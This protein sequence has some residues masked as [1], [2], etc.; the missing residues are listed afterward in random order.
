MTEYGVQAAPGLWSYPLRKGDTL[1]T[2]DWV[3]WHLHRF[4]SS[5]FVAQMIYR[6]RRDVIGT[7]MLLWSESYRQDPAGSLPDD[8]VELAQMARFGADVDGWKEMRALVLW[9]WS[10]C[11]IEDPARGVM[12]TNRLGHEVIAD[13]ASRSAK[14]RDGR[15]QGREAA[16][17][18][19]ARSRIKKGL[20]D[21]R[22]TRF[23]ENKDLVAA[24]SKWLDQS[25]LF[26][27]EENLRAG[28]EVVAGVPRV[29]A[30]RGGQTDSPRG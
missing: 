21:M 2:N 17:L 29:V 5:S 15:K 23:A 27:T 22:Q 7:A 9:G 25:N 16:R 19:V 26:I 12:I 3:E 11:E 28:L 18:A 10:P 4:L 30:L 6:Q 20:E 8:D 13:I 1:A 14:R 24:L